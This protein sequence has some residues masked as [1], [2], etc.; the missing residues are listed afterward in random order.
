MG[1]DHES[2]QQPSPCFA[3]ASTRAN[4]GGEAIIPALPIGPI[5]SVTDLH[6]K[7]KTRR[8]TKSLLEKLSGLVGADRSR[9]SP[10]DASARYKRLL[11]AKLSAKHSR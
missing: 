6:E 8:R 5:M 4:R 1:A 3:A 2:D 11:N 9:T 7:P 10:A